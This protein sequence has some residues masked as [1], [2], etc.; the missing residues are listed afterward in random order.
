MDPGDPETLYVVSGFN[1]LFR[2]ADLG[3]SWTPLPLEVKS[4]ADVLDFQVVAGDPATLWVATEAGLYRSGNA[5]SS[6]ERIRTRH[7]RYVSKTVAVHPQN[8][9]V[10]LTASSNVGFLRSDDGGDSWSPVGTGF[11]GATI[12]AIYAGAGTLF[13]QTSVGL[14]RGDDRG[15]WTEINEPFDDGEAEPDG[16]AFDR[17]DGDT[18]FGFDTSKLFRSTDGGRRWSEID[19]P[20]PS[21]AQMM[22]GNMDSPQF[23]SFVQDPKDPKVLYGGSWSNDSPGSAVFRTKNGGRKWEM[24]GNGLPNEDVS[25]LR[26][27]KS[28]TLFAVIDDIVYRTSNAGKTWSESNTGLP[29]EDLEDLIVDPAATGHVFVAS[30]TGLFRSTDE[31][32]SWSRIENGLAGDHVRAI[33]AGEGRLYVGTYDGVFVSQD[34]GDSFEMITGELPNDNVRALAVHGGSVFVGLYGGSVWEAAIE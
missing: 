34:G 21:M 26:S 13:A 28:G 31:G 14:F 19:V 27:E 5:G 25:L 12:E 4:T 20:E 24:A 3:N 29:G 10:L 11:T 30:E 23:K 2:S 15:S 6:W 16:I 22:R 1:E 9:S 32:S 18:V 8:P 7:G 17:K 33:A